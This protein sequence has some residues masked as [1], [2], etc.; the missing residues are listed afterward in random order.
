MLR[1]MMWSLYTYKT[2]KW[3]YL[4]P[5]AKNLKKQNTLLS[6]ISSAL[7][8]FMFGLRTEIWPCSFSMV[9]LCQ[10]GSYKITKWPHLSPQAKIS[11]YRCFAQCQKLKKAMIYGLMAKILPFSHNASYIHSI[12]QDRAEQDPKGDIMGFRQNKLIYNFYYF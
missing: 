3:P 11:K 12:W 9:A 4:C 1:V 5:Y 6:S 10:R 8:F 2:T 7:R